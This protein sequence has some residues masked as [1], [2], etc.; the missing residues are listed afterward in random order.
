MLFAV[1]VFTATGVAIAGPSGTI[2][3][4]SATDAPNPGQTITVTATLLSTQQIL[5]PSNVYYEIIAPD[6]VTVVATH[7]TSVPF[8]T[9]GQTFN[10]A[11]TT[12]NTSFPTA[13]TY[14]LN[15]CWSRLNWSN[16][17]L[18]R[19]ST[20]FYSVPILST[21]LWLVAA[22]LLAW[23]LWRRRSDFRPA[24]KAR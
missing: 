17:G 5:L 21:V 3:A 16:C 18:D 9:D 12:T 19:K 24:V 15:A 7:T 10:D 13:G 1:I 22:G 2:T 23:L 6:G 4:L 8:L 20:S 11:W 14:T